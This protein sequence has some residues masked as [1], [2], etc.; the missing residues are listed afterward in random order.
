MATARNRGVNA[1][2]VSLNIWLSSAEKAALVE[3]AGAQPLSAWLRCIALGEPVQ[4]SRSPRRERV[5][6]VASVMSPLV[7]AVAKVGNNLNQIARQV[8]TDSLGGRA[9]DV[10]EVRL[11]LRAI[12]ASLE[13]IREEVQRACEDLSARRS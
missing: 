4:A 12:R 6:V 2:N 3:R 9:I 8:N 10:I 5:G 1:R 7:L 13:D 11:A